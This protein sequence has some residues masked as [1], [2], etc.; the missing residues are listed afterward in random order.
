MLNKKM[1]GF[2]VLK[3]GLDMQ[4]YKLK[5]LYLI[6]QLILIGAVSVGKCCYQP[7]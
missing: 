2:F 5:S 4:K 7:I 3:K 1:F 6:L